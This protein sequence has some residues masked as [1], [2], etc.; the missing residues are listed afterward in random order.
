MMR[1]LAPFGG[2][3]REA[4]EI[5]QYFRHPVRLDNRRLV[6]LLGSEPHTPN[7]E[8]VRRTLVALRC[9]DQPAAVSSS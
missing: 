6:D 4:A 7:D 9:L 8:A 2:F 1:L 3:P 5:T